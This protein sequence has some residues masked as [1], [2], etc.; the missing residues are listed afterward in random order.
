MRLKWLAER[1]A[2]LALLLKKQT[3]KAGPVTTLDLCN[4]A[5]SHSSSRK[6]DTFA[7]MNFISRTFEFLQSVDCHAR[8]SAQR[9]I[10]SIEHDHPLAGPNL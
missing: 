8:S 9:S 3:D 10:H 5:P 6:E 7:M 4:T 2:V 1:G